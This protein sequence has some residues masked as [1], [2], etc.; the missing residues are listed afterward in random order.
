MDVWITILINDIKKGSI[1]QFIFTVLL[2]IGMTGYEVSRTLRPIT[3]TAILYWENGITTEEIE[4][5][6]FHELCE[7]MT[8][9][10]MSLFIG[11]SKTLED[12][13]T[14]LKNRHMLRTAADWQAYQYRAMSLI[15]NTE[16]PNRPHPPPPPPGRNGGGIEPGV[17]NRGVTNPDAL[18]GSGTSN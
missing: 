2:V 9:W 12:K 1:L 6:S 5:S 3:S 17:L 7:G 8:S 11:D 10:P 18:N 16:L 14:T 13:C 4:R 15:S